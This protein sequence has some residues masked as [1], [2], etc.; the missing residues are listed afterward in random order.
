MST[1]RRFVWL[2]LGGLVQLVLAQPAFAQ[3]PVVQ[4]R[5]LG[6]GVDRPIHD[7]SG[8]GD[9]SSIELN[10]A[11]LNG[12]YGLDVT[13][14]GY[15][16]LYEFARGA[17]FGAFASINLGWRFA[18]GFGVQALEPGF[19]GDLSD[20]DI[21]HNRPTTKLSLALAFG[22][23]EWGSFG[24]GVHGVRREGAAL[25]PASLDVGTVLRMTNYASFGAVARL[26]PAGLRDDSFRPTL[27]LAGE[28]A[29]RPLGNR[30]LEL[31]GGVTARVDQSEARGFSE[32]ELSEDLLPHG[33][34]AV[35]WQGLEI[36][37]E[38]QMIQADVLDED[39][40]DIVD[41]TTA[42]RG[43]VSMSMAWD[44]G[45]VGFGTHAGLGGSVDGLA[46]KARFTTQRQ[47]R[48]YWP[49]LVPIVTYHRD[50]VYLAERFNLE[51][52]ETLESKPGIAPSPS[53]LATV[54]GAMNARHAGVI[55][56]QPYQ[57]RRTAETVA[58]QAHA[59]VLDLSQQP[60]AIPNTETYFALMDHLIQTLAAALEKA[61]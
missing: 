43:G 45:S 55:I 19:R 33:R 5:E 13:L 41:R 27:D 4:H 38:A 29:V 1:H 39:T 10:P 54:I 49:R 48:V 37:G 40:L 60:G 28:L 17:G 59:S 3:D 6:D 32:F 57:N 50:F 18:L 53:H 44:Y 26:G 23:G 61:K 11:M 15:Q 24:L 36:A 30:W 21:A 47:G 8:S 20:A 9:A 31:A 16:A 58:R 14:L 7:L 42:M 52:L 22:Q 34:V 2:G 25:R 35:R 46:Y 51:V 56:V 12:V